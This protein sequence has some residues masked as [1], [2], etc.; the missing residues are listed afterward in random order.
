MLQSPPTLRV[1]LGALQGLSAHR[2]LEE[3]RS[4]LSCCAALLWDILVISAEKK[5]K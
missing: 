4:M 5:K 1:N 3:S 2:L